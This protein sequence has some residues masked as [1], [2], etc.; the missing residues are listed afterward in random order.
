MCRGGAPDHH[1]HALLVEVELCAPSHSVFQMLL[2]E[3]MKVKVF[4][5]DI[6]AFMEGQNKELPSVAEEV[7]SI[8]R[9]EEKTVFAAVD[10]GTNEG[11]NKASTHQVKI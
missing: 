8:R 1:G 11:Q 3:E 5:D 9:E 2:S 6:A 4:V 10:H 7:T